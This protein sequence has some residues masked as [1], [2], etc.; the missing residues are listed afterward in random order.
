MS[1]VVRM[2]GLTIISNFHDSSTI[3]TISMI[4]H[5]LDPAIRKMDIILSL[6]VTSLIASS[7]LSKVCVVF[8]IMDSILVVEWV[9]MF[10]IILSTTSMESM[11]TNTTQT[12]ERNGSGCSSWT[13]YL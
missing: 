9:W 1:M 6:H 7:L 2:L 10:I 5:M 11:M 4:D 13:P 3:V 8:V 12:L